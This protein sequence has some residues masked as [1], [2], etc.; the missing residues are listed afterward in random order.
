MDDWGGV[1]AFILVI[2]LALPL[3]LLSAELTDANDDAVVDSLVL[4]ELDTK[5]T[6]EVIIVL[7]ESLEIQDVKTEE[8]LSLPALKQAI[9]NQQ[10][11]VIQELDSVGVQVEGDPGSFQLK[12]KYNYLNSMHLEI[13][14]ATLE[15]LKEIPEVKSIQVNEIVQLQLNDSVG[16][17]EANQLYS[18][19]INLTNI[20]GM[21]ETICVLDSGINYS[22]KHLGD[23][24]TADFTTGN[25]NKVPGGYDYVNN[26][27]DPYD[28]STSS[29]GTFS[30]GIIASNDTLY[31]GIAP[32]SKI[33]SMKVCNA[34]GSC[35]TNAILAAL[36]SCVGNST[37]YNISVISMSLGT[38]SQYTSSCDSQALASG[39]NDAAS[40]GLM[41]VAAA[42]NKGS[43]SSTSGISSPACGS[44]VISV[45]ST[46]KSDTISTFSDA[47]SILDLLAPGSSIKSSNKDNTFSAR[48]GTSFSAPHV[49]GAIALFMQAARKI[50]KDNNAS[51]ELSR[52]QI[53][54]ALKTTGKQ[55]TDSRL[56]LNFSRI[57]VSGAFDA[58]F[59]PNITFVSPT[60]SNGSRQKNATFTINIT[61]QVNLSSALF[62]INGTNYSMGA[63]G[64][65][66]KR[67]NYTFTGDGN[68]SYKIHGNNSG[69]IGVSASREIEINGSNRIP[70][71]NSYVPTTI[72]ISII[73]PSNQTFNVSASDADTE[74]TISYTWYQNG[75]IVGSNSYEFNFTEGYTG[76]GNHNITS[77]VSDGVANS[78]QT[79]T[80]VINNTNRV[81]I[82]NT[83]PNI[84]INE[85][86][87]LNFNST[88]QLNATDSDT[89]DILTYNATEL[90]G[91]FVINQTSL[92][93]TTLNSDV[94][95]YRVNISVSDGKG[96]IDSQ[97]IRVTILNTD[98]DND[99]IPD[100][101]EVD[102]DN[103]GV[104][105]TSDFLLGN[106]SDVFVANITDFNISVNNSGNLSK[107]FNGSFEVRF[108]ERKTTLVLFNFVFN[109][110]NTLNLPNISIRKQNS[111]GR[112]SL[113]VRG[114]KGVSKTLYVDNNSTHDGVCVKNAEIDFISEISSACTGTSETYV[115]CPGSS[116]SFGCAADGTK[117]A[118][119]GLTDSGVIQQNKTPDPPAG[120][121]G[122]GGSSGGPSS[123]STP[124]ST[125]VGNGSTQTE[126][127]QMEHTEGSGVEEE[128][129]TSTNVT[130][131][132]NKASEIVIKKTGTL[133]AFLIGMGI[134]GGEGPVPVSLMAIGAMVVMLVILL[135][136]RHR[137]KRAKN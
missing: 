67:W 31:Q 6:V 35:F 134:I 13:D 8:K 11:N 89:D 77:V 62:E 80:L 100:F 124:S 68:Y 127:E 112:G 57:N 75:S 25:C 18:Q 101:N 105:D 120:P 33:F 40:A 109:S 36:S 118:V 32:D 28:N 15:K 94:G 117:W 130:T 30:S 10:D 14:R 38:T 86:L 49:S 66:S 53:L 24:S 23:C 41:V 99:G 135:A 27:N 123:S 131:T 17:I 84:T 70:V 102:D 65:S 12:S 44:S 133:E 43:T 72:N 119:S 126:L 132:E 97:V 114:L 7:E 63:L 42:G 16:L 50:N 56:D 92:N 5:D 64:S 39:S 74:D 116:G 96:G 76:A 1:I 37:D 59:K 19:R 110:T 122:P 34:T 26:D 61:S 103:D 29:H 79:W 91:S 71:I 136:I 46:T 4:E 104:L 137:I 20:T 87:V 115:A 60:P 73:E 98:S 83:Q 81:P 69:L 45:G 78:S 111:N 22:L 125:A 95:I 51:A 106:S 85:T 21:G 121:S 9:S 48:S 58:L 55:I 108:M 128:I 3:L 93:Y 113:I 88:G 90:S 107:A 2:I 47:A 82:L 129:Q 54:S 52:A